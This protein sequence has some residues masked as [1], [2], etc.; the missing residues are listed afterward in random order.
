MDRICRCCG[1]AAKLLRGDRVIV[2]IE[3]ELLDKRKGI[4]LKWH[5]T[6]PEMA[7]VLLEGNEKP[8]PLDT[9]FLEKMEFDSRQTRLSEY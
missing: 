3:D 1:I 5:P 8:T 4:I 9:T 6:V 7:M 2:D